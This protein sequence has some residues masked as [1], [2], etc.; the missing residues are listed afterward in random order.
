MFERISRGDLYRYEKRYTDPQTKRVSFEAVPCV[1]ISRDERNRAGGT[2]L[3]ATIST[4][5]APIVYPNEQFTIS[6]GRLKNHVVSAGC[7]YTMNCSKLN[8]YLGDLEEE[9]LE[10]LDECLLNALGIDLE[11]VDDEEET[12]QRITAE[13]T[14]FYALDDAQLMMERDFYKSRYEDL[15]N[16]L[17]G[18]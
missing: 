6:A 14:H 18:K 7:I 8:Q 4:T 16:R 15:L 17:I 12:N 5:V 1:V 13:E 10:Q 2:C 11:A 9:D 3:V